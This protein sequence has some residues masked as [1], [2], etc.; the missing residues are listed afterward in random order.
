[1][2]ATN[3]SYYRVCLLATCCLVSVNAVGGLIGGV[4]GVTQV[5]RSEWCPTSFLSLFE[6]EASWSRS[7]A[8][9]RLP[10]LHNPT[11]PLT[12]PWSGRIAPRL[13]PCEVTGGNWPSVAGP[14]RIFLGKAMRAQ[15]RLKPG[16]CWKRGLKLP[17][18]NCGWLFNV[19]RPVI[20]P[21]N[22]RDRILHF[23]AAA[24]ALP[25][26]S[27]TVNRCCSFLFYSVQYIWTPATCHPHVGH[28][29]V[30]KQI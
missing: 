8:C 1:M 13:A 29:V 9:A 27:S 18:L 7:Q 15:L 30:K 28:F 26:G 10:R 6:A 11:L 25:F 17:A 14:V 19:G 20:L 2:T 16:R 5:H 22:N 12:W 3:F 4:A 24:T 21:V 23:A